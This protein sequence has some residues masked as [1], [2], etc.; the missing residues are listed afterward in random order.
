MGYIL[1][2][3]E[4]TGL[5]EEDR[6]CQLCYGILDDNLEHFEL[7]DAFVKPPVDIKFQTMAIHH[8]T[9]EMVKDKPSCQESD[10]FQKLLTLN[11]PQHIMVIHNAKFDLDMLQK[12]GFELQ[13]PL[14]DT[15]R[16]AKHLYPQE[17]SC[18]M[19][20]LRYAWGV[21]QARICPQ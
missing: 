7:F 17:P 11:V 16:C 15:F 5:L 1:L 4:T 20:V 21:V 9:R 13:T 12:E 2:D 14:I 3:T 19:Q 10:I 18:A 6:I 8:I